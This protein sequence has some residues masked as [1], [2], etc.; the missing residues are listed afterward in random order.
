MKA[1]LCREFGPLEG[2]ALEEVSSPIAGNDQ[3][4]VAVKAAGVN[5]PDTLIVQ[6]K[7]QSAPPCLFH[8]AGSSPVSS[9]KW[10]RVSRA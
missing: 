7:Y 6:G 9:S 2:L 10:A 4:V 1:L 3:V 5:F 8:R